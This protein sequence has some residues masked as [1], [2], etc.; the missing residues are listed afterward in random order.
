MSRKLF[1]LAVLAACLLAS[2]CRPETT[3]SAEAKSPDGLWLATARS[4]QWSGPGNAYD[5]TIVYLKR[6][7]GT[8]PPT[9]ILGFSQQYAT[10][11]LEMEWAT[12]MHLDVSYGPSTR[13]G[14]QVSLDFQVARMGGIVITVH[15]LSSESAS[16][17]GST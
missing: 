4:Q 8:E 1:D 13:P 11:N 3:W 5:A 2:G 6:T 17:K 7:S 12:P 9:E 16:G 10:M 14:D 15:D